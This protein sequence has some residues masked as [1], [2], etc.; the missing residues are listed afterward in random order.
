MSRNLWSRD[1]DF[2]ELSEKLSSSAKAYYP[3]TDEFKAANERWSN[4]DVPT[5]NIVVVPGTENDVVETVSSKVSQ[6]PSCIHLSPPS[7]S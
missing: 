1:A 6:N 5:V 7:P 2:K 4:L 3:G